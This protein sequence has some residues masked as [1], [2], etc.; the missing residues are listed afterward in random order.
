VEAAAADVVAGDGSTTRVVGAEEAAPDCT[1]VADVGVGLP[2]VRMTVDA[3]AADGE[4]A[5]ATAPTAVADG[6]DPELSRTVVTAAG[7]P[8]APATPD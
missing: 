4:E 6:D 1:V 8:T 3:A 2:P 7:P 5:E